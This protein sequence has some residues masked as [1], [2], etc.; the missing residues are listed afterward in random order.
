VPDLVEA[1]AL[2]GRTAEAHTV[3]DDFERDARRT[4]RPSALALA[5]R[6]RAFLAPDSELDARFKDALEPG[7]ETTGPFD[8]ARTELLYGSR[9]AGQGRHSEARDRLSS[10]FQAFGELGAES[11]DRRSRDE[12]VAAGGV[13]PRSHPN[14]LERLT[15]LEL[16]VALAAAAGA[17]LDD[18]AHN[19][20]LGPRTARLLLASTM[21]K[22]GAE[23]TDQLAAALGPERLPHA[24]AG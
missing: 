15:R 6:C 8:R 9:L 13:A 23:S 4:L 19:L 18:V 12:I 14:R 10:A 20:F 2:A 24:I 3:L 16:E 5:A 7:V 22:L 1:Y 11:W 21:A 17:P